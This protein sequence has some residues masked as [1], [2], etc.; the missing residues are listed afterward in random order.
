MPAVTV[1]EVPEHSIVLLTG[2]DIP[3]AMSEAFT[4]SLREAV[5]HD[6]FVVLSA[7]HPGG[8]VTVLSDPD[9][10]PEW[11]LER[12]TEHERDRLADHTN[13]GPVNTRQPLRLGKNAVRR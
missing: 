7:E 8:A 13:R 2:F 3:D 4:D 5:G 10:F 12:L 1:N 9:A 11:L 6:N